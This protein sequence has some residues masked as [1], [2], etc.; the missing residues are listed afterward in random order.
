MNYKF[1]KL[2]LVNKP[3]IGMI[4]LAGNGLNEKINR[5]LMELEIFQEEGID[6]AIVEDYHAN[7]LDLIESLGEISKRKWNIR[8]GINWLTNPRAV[9]STAND[10]GASFV[11]LDSVQ[12]SLDKY[13]GQRKEF[14]GLV[15]L[16]GIRFKY[17][18]ISGKS[19]IEDIEEGKPRCDAVVT[20]GEGTG[21]E[22]PI[23]KLK[24]FRELL[25]DFP[26]ISGAGVDLSNIHEQLQAADSV[27]IG[28][29]FKPHKDTYLPV[30]RIKVRDIMS[31]VREFRKNTSQWAQ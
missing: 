29:Y 17:Q 30:D 26:L 16:G 1:K 8:L 3:I 31:E 5:A 25:G 6:G 19:L 2:F 10:Y 15:V 23:R 27:I 4:H 11:Q 28:S 18:P 9:F 24:Q 22:T 20:T 12:G 14:P 21:I 7:S 13:A